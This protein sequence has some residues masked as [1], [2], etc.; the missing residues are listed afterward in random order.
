MNSSGFRLFLSI[1]SKI[2]SLHQNQ[3]N[4]VLHQ[5]YSF[6]H[7]YILPSSFYM[8]INFHFICY[9]MYIVHVIF[10]WSSYMAPGTM[11]VLVRLERHGNKS[12]SNG[13]YIIENAYSIWHEKLF[14]ACLYPIYY[15]VT[16]TQQF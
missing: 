9:F 5:P 8:M 13:E 2:W 1:S 7:R 12:I 3:I 10:G 14:T 16:L 4:I 6:N 15:I 11:L